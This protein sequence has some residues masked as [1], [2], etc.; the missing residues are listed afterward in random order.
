M[1]DWDQRFKDEAIYIHEHFPDLKYYET[2]EN[3][4]VVLGDIILADRDGM[5]IDK[6]QVRIVPSI[7]YPATFPL[8]FE[9]GGRIPIN[10]DWHVYSD[11]HCCIKTLAEELLICKKGIN[12]KDFIEKHVVPYFFNQ[13][14][15]ELH[16]YFLQEYS[17]GH[18][19]II[20]FFEDQFNTKNIN[21]ILN[22]LIFI[23][24]RREPNRVEDCFCGSG[25]KYRKC[26]RDTY[27]ILKEF[28]NDQLDI[29]IKT[30]NDYLYTLHVKL[31]I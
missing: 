15:R 17:H 8:V 1:N 2:Q 20:E 5:P 23:K 26:H 11:G 13:K 19:G 28:N 30:I 6:Y 31:Q 9:T 24:S 25:R 14:H 4:P 18:K 21:L 7:N 10:I 16:G 3:G 12:L 27:R 22:G 29:I